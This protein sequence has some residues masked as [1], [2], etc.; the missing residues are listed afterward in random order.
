MVSTEEHK[1]LLWNAVVTASGDP[2][3][4]AFVAKLYQENDLPAR[5]PEAFARA[6][7]TYAQTRI[8]YVRES[9]ETFV[10]PWRTIEWGIADCDD[11]V[12]LI[13]STLRSIRIPVRVV[14]LGW[15]DAP[16]PAPVPLKHVYTEAYIDGA[17]VPL[18]AVRAVPYGWD[19]SKFQTEK[20]RRIRLETLGDQP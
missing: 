10:A 1:R 4:R 8:K 7:Q 13:A 11:F 6:L 5:D 19:P 9:D 18:E 2:R 14:F 15:T 3:L 20:G 17:W 16:E 12:I